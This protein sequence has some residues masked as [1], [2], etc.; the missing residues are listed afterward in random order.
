MATLILLT[1]PIGNL[2]DLTPRAKKIIED[3][4]IFLAEDTRVF[5]SLCDH[6]NID[7]SQKRV[8]SFND[9]DQKSV[10][11]FLKPLEEGQ[12]VVVVS[13]AGSPIISDPA[14]PL[15]VEAYR[16]GHAVDSRPGVSSIVVALELSGLPIHPF[17]FHGFFPRDSKKQGEFIT[18]VKQMGGTQVLFES[19]HR[20]L[21]SLDYLTEQIPKAQFAISREL[22]KKFQETIRFSGSE[23]SGIR[24]DL[25]VKGE[26]VIVFYLEHEFAQIVGSEIL[27]LAN[28]VLKRN[29]PKNLSKLL[30]NLLGKKSKDIYQELI[31]QKANPK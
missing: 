18:K 7:C 8:T 25:V 1:T 17:T 30:G 22:T 2:D 6:L 21:E 10:S 12:N 27:E 4:R 19:P 15:V 23:W 11:N 24:N 13:D 3:E 28:D 9:H 14:Y 20:I 5:M 29:D 31:Q 16:M 26:F